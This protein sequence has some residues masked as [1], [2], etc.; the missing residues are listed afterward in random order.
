MLF[1]L[2]TEPEFFQGVVFQIQ[3]LLTLNGFLL[4]VEME[5]NV[6]AVSCNASKNHAVEM[7]DTC[8]HIRLLFEKVELASKEVLELKAE[9]QAFLEN[10]RASQR[11]ILE[12]VAE[13][14]GMLHQLGRNVVLRDDHNRDDESDD[15]SS[16][17]ENS[18]GVVEDGMI[19]SD[20]EQE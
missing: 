7:E 10:F 11:E 13:I 16:G 17:E 4:Q 8:D 9:L 12:N 18:L 3:Y 14:R 15:S 5:H 20:D 1:L 19:E 2:R 6:D